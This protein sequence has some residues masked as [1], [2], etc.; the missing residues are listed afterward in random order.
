MQYDVLMIYIAMS[1]MDTH[2]HIIM[3]VYT[4]PTILLFHASPE[5]RGSTT[6]AAV[7]GGCIGES[8]QVK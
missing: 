8:L 7:T 2:M 4:Y 5:L 6:T 3:C 1:M